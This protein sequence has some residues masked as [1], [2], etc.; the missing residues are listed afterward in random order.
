MT[1]LP[2]SARIY[3]TAITLAA[4]G[5]T[6]RLL[7]RA[8][9]PSPR[10][11]VLALAGCGLI[12]VATYRPL[13]LSFKRKLVLDTSVLV[14][15]VLLLPA[16]VAVLVGV[17]GTLLVHAIRH[18]DWLQAVFNASQVALATAAA[19]F[20]LRA[21]GVGL[22]DGALDRPAAEVAILVA[23]VAM[24]AVGNAVVATIVA[25]E[26]GMSPVDVWR[27]VVRQADGGEVLGHLAQV[28]LGAA[29]AVAIAVAPWSLPLALLPA[30]AVSVLLGRHL[31][32]RWEAEAALRAS[33]ADLTRVERVGRL[34]RW[35][36]DL[37]TGVHVWSAEAHRL[38]GTPAGGSPP[39]F[40]TLLAAVHPADRS[41]VDRAVHAALAA[42]T[43]FRLDHRVRLP[44]GAERT[45]HQEGAPV[46][47]EAGRKVR[48]VGTLQDV[49]EQR[50]LEARV[51]E[52][53]ERHRAA[54]DVADARGRLGA[55]RELERLR[56]ARELHDGPL[57][58]LIAIS[59]EL[60]GSERATGNGPAA[61]VLAPGVMRR[62]VLA[63]VGQL[64]GVIGELRPPGLLELGLVAA[65]EGY[66]ASLRRHGDPS[67]PAIVL[68]ADDPWVGLPEPVALALF[69]IAQ[70]AVRNAI[71]HADARTV[72]I[73]L[74]HEGGDVALEVEDDG[75][76]F[77]M[78]ARL[79]DLTRAGHFGLVGLAERVDQAC[80]TLAIRSSIGAGTRIAVRLPLVAPVGADD[81]AAS[82]PDRYVEARSG[83]GEGGWGSARPPLP[84]D[85]RGV[86]FGGAAADIKLADPA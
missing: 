10:D 33:A 78:P 13:P 82:V 25:L 7:A 70:E 38:L 5:L 31:R 46:W 67:L 59:Y 19:A 55:S 76:G 22:R 54:T 11:G 62:Q 9:S 2:L 72:C 77:A 64:R 24:Y 40:A 80:G 20:V 34:G 58:D 84:E 27:R 30:V 3:A 81:R 28:G 52:I 69:R 85:G 4:L 23:G 45:V 43:V 32:M 26:S 49:T 53:A 1:Q 57:Q 75:R 61:T 6:I 35:E 65:L 86:R 18:D 8:G 71:R 47:D 21:A 44:D 37:T 68:A 12:V 41:A 79:N 14:A 48:L 16:G 56:L 73:R 50:T 17:T 83:P 60:A 39:T 15:A 74:R 63:V 36:W 42:G 66:V 51:E 29:V